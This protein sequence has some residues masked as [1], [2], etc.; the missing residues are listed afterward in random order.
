MK[1]ETP[2]CR[3]YRLRIEAQLRGDKHYLTGIP[4]RNGHI[5]LRWVCNQKCITCVSEEKA[6]NFENRRKT[7]RRPEGF[8]KGRSRGRETMMLEIAALR[9]TVIELRE[10]LEFYEGRT[11]PSV[12][13]CRPAGSPSLTRACTP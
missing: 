2:K 9:A 8:K 5:T 13:R 1:A 4:C 3:A 11:G 7:P 10:K 6:R 12:P